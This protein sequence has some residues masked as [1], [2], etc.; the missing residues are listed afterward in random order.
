MDVALRIAL[1][2]AAC[3][4]AGCPKP[5]SNTP[6]PG[7]S[8]TGAGAT[9]PVATPGPSP[10]VVA[11]VAPGPSGE[12][13]AKA[14]SGATDGPKVKTMFVHEQ[15]VDCQGEGPMRCMQIRE[16]ESAEWIWFYDHIEGF[17]HEPSHRYELRVEVTRVEHP[18]ADGSALR[19][20]LVE[21]VSK[22]K[23]APKPAAR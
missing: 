4:V 8:A 10:T 11:A 14:H 2:V 5:T 15:L 7:S 23:I 19:Y 16:S 13:S 21:V 18:P 3:L 1:V 6:P 12:P 20:R 9:I 22:T 17:E